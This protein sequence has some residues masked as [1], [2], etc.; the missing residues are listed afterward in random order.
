M[1]STIDPQEAPSVAATPAAEAA[2][3]AAP[4]GFAGFSIS[5]ETVVWLAVIAVAATIR[6]ARLEHLPLTIDESVRALASWQTGQGNVPDGW[7]GD[8]TQAVTAYLFAI[9]GAGD[10]LARLAPALLGCLAVALCWP[11]SRYTSGAALVAAVLLAVSPLLVHVS[12]S[13]LP[14]AAGAA[15]S[16]GMATA[17]F[18]FLKTRSPLSLFFLAMAVGLALGSDAVATSTAILLVV[19]LVLEAT[20]FHSPA[21]GEA[22]TDIRPNRALMLSALL[23][24][25]GALELGVTRFGTDVDRFS[26]PGL[27]LW[28][29][30]FDL[31]RDDLPWL[32]HPGIL[33]SY[34]AP[35]LILGTVGYLWV[36]YRWVRGGTDGV[37]LFQ[38]FLIVWASGAAIII[39]SV[40]RREAGQLVLLLLP[41]ALLAGCWL[42]GLLS[43]LSLASLGRSLPFLTPVLFAVVYLV[44]VLTDWARDGNVG[45]K[46]GPADEPATLILV[47][48]GAIALLWLAWSSL[49]RRAITGYVLLGSLISFVF[50]V[51]G[52]TSVTYGR[53]SEFLADERLDR[54]VPRLEEQLA[55][56]GGAPGA[57]AADKSFLPALGWYLRDV[58][59]LVFAASPPAEANTYLAVP[60]QPAPAGYRVD[61]RWPIAQGWV[62]HTIDGL[63]WWRWLVYREPY[64]GLTS[65][66]ADL[67]VKGQ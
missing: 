32:F 31:P 15:L 29:D 46:G 17:L 35:A 62:P 63:D 2:A 34:E 49:G 48:G 41:L 19:F 27:R 13:G 33:I 12:R 61:R 8:L 56:M 42:E 65:T 60:G 6:L 26:L 53:G 30:M 52:A 21:V 10:Q 55:A 47:T 5:L 3:T 64:G 66:E 59:G 20:I 51:H 58:P 36:L 24:F 45:G 44:L 25:L 22:L 57:I 11:L 4:A 39:A 54:Q 38:R 23:I 67:L 28:S 40:T 16:L 9:F 14:Y 50:L 1:S 18:A 37:P 43:E 7:S